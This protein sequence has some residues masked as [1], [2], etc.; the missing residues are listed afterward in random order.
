M[1][2]NRDWHNQNSVEVSLRI[3]QVNTLLHP[4]NKGAVVMTVADVDTSGALQLGGSFV[5]ADAETGV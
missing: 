2:Q 4:F 1:I 3:A 5:I